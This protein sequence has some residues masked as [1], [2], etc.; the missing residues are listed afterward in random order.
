MRNDIFLES[1]AKVVIDNGSISR[2][3]LMLEQQKFFNAF[4]SKISFGPTD[5]SVDLADSLHFH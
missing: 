4:S 3:L 5:K 1:F 2:L